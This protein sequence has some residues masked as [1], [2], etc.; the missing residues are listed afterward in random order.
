M[1]GGLYSHPTTIV[2]SLPVCFF[3]IISKYAS[4]VLRNFTAT[5][6]KKCQLNSLIAG[7]SRSPTLKASDDVTSKVLTKRRHSRLRL[8]FQG[9]AFIVVL[10]VLW[11]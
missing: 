4:R 11:V 7:L 8:L 1:G 5:I 9:G 3:Y 2:H 6:G 10:F